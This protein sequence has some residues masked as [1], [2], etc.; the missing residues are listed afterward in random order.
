LFDFGGAAFVD[1]VG[2]GGGGGGGGGAGIFKAIYSFKIF[3]LI[4]N[5]LNKILN[6]YLNYKQN[7]N[8][9]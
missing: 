7:M 1:E 5:I 8:K 4:K 3:K 9:R 2:G 6:M